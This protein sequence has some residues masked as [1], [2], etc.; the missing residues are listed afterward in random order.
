MD[1]LLERIPNL[2]IY[3]QFRQ[4]L[5]AIYSLRVGVSKT[6]G[7]HPQPPDYK[8]WMQESLLKKS[9]HHWNYINSIGYASVKKIAA[10]TKFEDLVRDS[11]KFSMDI[12]VQLEIDPKL[13]DLELKSWNRKVQN[14]NN[15]D[16]IEA[17]TSRPYSTQDH[18]KKINR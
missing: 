6:W 11:S 3:W 1:V 5:D 17:L 10:V 7:H 16:F 15:E 9:S 13:H 14:N 18:R 12:C 2:K 4:P 8:D